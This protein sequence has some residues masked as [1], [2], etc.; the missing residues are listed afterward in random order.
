MPLFEYI[1][2]PSF[3]RMLAVYLDDEEY[4]QLQRNL[5]DRPETGV[6]VP[7]SGGV[8][9]LR[10]GLSGRGKRGGLRVLYYVASSAGQ[11]WML[12]IHA[13]NA[14]AN[15]PAHV[16]NELRKVFENAQDV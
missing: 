14:H 16:L 9:K 10:W 13:K 11:I 2:A 15:V 6:V 4:L 1:E 3:T 5:N 12:S 8:R 7:G